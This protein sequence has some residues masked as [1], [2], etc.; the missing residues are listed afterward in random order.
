MRSQ[1]GI[2]LLDA[3]VALVIMTIMIGWVIPFTQRWHA[4][5]LLDAQMRDVQGLMQQAQMASLDH[6]RPWTLCGSHDGLRCDGQWRHLLVLDAEGQVRY[7]AKRHD[8]LTLRWKGLS[9]ALVFHPHLSS[10]MLNG[11]FHIC[12]AQKTRQLIVNRLGR[13]RFQTTETE[14]D[15]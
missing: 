9:S 1:Q 11:T 8:P 5:R 6:G 13:M 4:N 15:C 10:S 3:M 14:G 12:H 7:H 2:T